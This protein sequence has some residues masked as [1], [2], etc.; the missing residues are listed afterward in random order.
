MSVDYVDSVREF[1]RR[2]EPY[3]DPHTTKIGSLKVALSPMFTW[4]GKTR[5]FRRGPTTWA[6]DSEKGYCA[7]TILPELE[8]GEA[9]MAV[10]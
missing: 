8:K 6:E 1:V 7:R 9:E 2:M 10:R 5:T 3:M 4:S